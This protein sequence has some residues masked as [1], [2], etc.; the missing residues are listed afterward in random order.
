MLDNMPLYSEDLI[1]E[2]QKIYIRKEY[3]PSNKIEEIM[4]EEG[5]MDVIKYLSELLKRHDD[6]LES[7]EIPENK[8]RR[9]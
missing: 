3:N 9:N 6:H 1:R 7:K 4:F 5:R 2:L 8:I